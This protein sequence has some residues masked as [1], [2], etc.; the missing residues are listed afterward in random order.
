MLRDIW[1][2][3]LDLEPPNWRRWIKNT[4]LFQERWP[5]AYAKGIPSILVA[6]LCEFLLSIFFFRKKVYYGRQTMQNLFAGKE[7]DSS[8]F[9]PFVSS[10]GGGGGRHPT[11]TCHSPFPRI[12]SAHL[13]VIL[14]CSSPRPS[15]GMMSMIF[16]MFLK[17]FSVFPYAWVYRRYALFRPSGFIAR[18]SFVAQWADFDPSWFHAYQTLAILGEGFFFLKRNKREK[19]KERRV[20]KYSACPA[21]LCVQLRCSP[22]NVNPSFL[23]FFF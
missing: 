18:D 4:L 6:I 21:S 8:T 3:F 1:F 5:D 20:L 19:R 11:P 16:G 17:G 12:P 14:F 2:A 7:R 10:G 15:I 13:I 23:S 22:S 9:S